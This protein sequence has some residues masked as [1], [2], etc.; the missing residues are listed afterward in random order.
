[1]SLTYLYLWLLSLLL[2]SA[3]SN[4]ALVISIEHR[5]VDKFSKQCRDVTFAHMIAM[6]PSISL[7]A[8]LKQTLKKKKKKSKYLFAV[9]VIFL[10]YF[11]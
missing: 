2:F 7:A 8:K 3:I 1:M 6:V 5:W 10:L 11:W 9:F 4:E